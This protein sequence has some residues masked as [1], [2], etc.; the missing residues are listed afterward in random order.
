MSQADDIAASLQ[1][2]CDAMAD[3][4]LPIC[5]DVNAVLE[6]YVRDQIGIHDHSL[7][8][9]AKLGH[10]YRVAGGGYMRQ[11]KKGQWQ[12]GIHK[13]ARLQRE[14][15]LGHDIKLVHVQSKTLWDA[16]YNRVNRVGNSILA[17]VGVDIQKAPYAPWVIK[18]TRRM[19]PRD[20]LGIGALRAR[21]EIHATLRVGINDVAKAV[22]AQ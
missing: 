22:G 4:L 3:A 9:L 14:Q 17:V 13:E 15:S 11:N 8:D 20:F 10:P 5:R 21:S 6:H 18:G 7:K 16:L 19:I 1:Q 12:G 2:R